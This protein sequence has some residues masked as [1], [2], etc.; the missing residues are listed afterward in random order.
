MKTRVILLS[1]A[2][3]LTFDV[4]AATSVLELGL[5][6]DGTTDDTAALQKAL[7][8]GHLD[9]H[10]PPGTYLL[11]TVELPK[12]ATIRFAPQARVKVE[13]SQIVELANDEDPK[14]NVRPLWLLKGDRILVEGLDA[15]GV[16]EAQG[17]DKRGRARA[18]VNHIIYGQGVANVSFSRLRAVLAEKKPRELPNLI[19]L[20]ECRDIVLT[21]SH[22]EN[23]GH[24][25]RVERCRNVSVHGN[26][27]LFCNTI[28]TF[29]H[30]ESL[31][32]YDNWS[33]RV[34]YQCVFRGG[35]PDPS[36]KAP[37]VPLGSADKVV[38]GL[39]PKQPGYNPHLDGT[40]DIQISH[41]Y[42]EYGRTLAWGNKARQVLFEGNISRF[43]TDY[44][45]G[46][47][48]CENVVFANNTSINAKS[49]GIMS[50]Y[51]GEK[52]V[53]TGNLVIVRDEPYV[54]EFSQC[55]SQSGYWG[56]LLRFHHGPTTKA[57]AAAGSRYGAGKAFVSGNLLVNELHDRLRSISI[58]AG[59]DV[60]LSANKIVNG[61]IRK[62]GAGDVSI[63][64]NEFVSDMPLPHGIVGLGAGT[65]QAIVKD[66]IMRFTAGKPAPAAPKPA[67]PTGKD[68]AEP[69]QDTE[70]LQIA[71][72]AISNTTGA[73]TMTML[74]VEGNVI[75]GWTADAIRLDAALRD[76]EPIR[77]I[78]RGNSVEGAIR[79]AGP[80]QSYRSVV[81]N[82]L[83]LKTLETVQ[84][85]LEPQ[86]TAAP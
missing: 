10:F 59:R 14:D 79:I 28:T 23:L 51:W 71:L 21:D 63:L 4:S 81:T 74:L 12:N 48:G 13:S 25:L 17:K 36:R 2:L 18:A 52:L 8:D 80:P 41:N 19:G 29:T 34:I 75:Q 64:G 76:G 11:G 73:K 3:S 40:Y 1:I 66:N 70:K 37:R 27:A 49:V 47:E 72:P 24:G 5:K 22:I 58:E 69:A 32:H 85:V 68:E 55:E 15:E 50:M 53:I 82:N 65:G 46:V 62:S 9:L 60:T 78:V 43:M 67:A 61:W 44:S 77:F 31:R 16:F 57:D 35:S 33:R 6:G 38:R 84:P 86:P 45:Y 56:G 20:K 26:R 54:Q 30:S 83:H 39:D 7:A 42:A